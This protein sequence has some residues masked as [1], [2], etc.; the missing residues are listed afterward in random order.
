M[1]KAFVKLG[2]KILRQEVESLSWLLLIA[3]EREKLKRELTSLQA[4]FQETMESPEIARLENKMT[5]HQIKGVA[6]TTQAQG[7]DQI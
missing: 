2:E 7:E 3:F 1:P 5:S 4:E 6:I